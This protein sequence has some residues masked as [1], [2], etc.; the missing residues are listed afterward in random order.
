VEIE[1]QNNILKSER[2][3]ELDA[4][5]GI[6]ALMVMFFHFSM[7][8]PECQMGFK[9]GVSGVSLFFIISGFVIF[10]SI[11]NTEKSNIFLRNRFGRLFPTYWTIVTFTYIL[12]VLYPYFKIGVPPSVGLSNY[13][14]NLTMVQFYLGIPDLDGSYWSLIVELTFYFL[15]YLAIV[16]KKTK[17]IMSIGIPSTIIITFLFYFKE[18]N[19]TVNHFFGYFP[20]ACHLPLFLA[21][22][23]FYKI[24]ISIEGRLKNSIYLAIMFVLQLILFHKQYGDNSSFLSYKEHTFTLIAFYTIFILLVYKKLKI[25]VN[26]V[27]LFFGKIS[28][29]MY[30]IHQFL[31]YY[32]IMPYATEK[33]HLNFWVAAFCVTFPIIV[34]LSTVITYF[35][36]IPVNRRLKKTNLF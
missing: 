34:L 31:G 3:L 8:R 24:S 4:L 23:S 28:Y 17:Q 2:N 7:G 1:T 13:F 26:K 25:I 9:Y 29:S 14:G 21:G 22:I 32:Y 5:R 15:I 12:T 11:E 30:L 16:F 10:K 35:V 18:E 36:E 19:A 27:T 6:A 33:L 20:I